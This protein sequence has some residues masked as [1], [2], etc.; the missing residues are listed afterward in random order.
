MRCCVW[1]GFAVQE[2]S[3]QIALLMYIADGWIWWT[4]YV[5]IFDATW[6][7]L[8]IPL[9]QKWNNLFLQASVNAML[10]FLVLN[11]CTILGNMQFI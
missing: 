5:G 2:G 11:A 1:S 8:L 6:K 7:I 3:D 10:K 4:C 9:M